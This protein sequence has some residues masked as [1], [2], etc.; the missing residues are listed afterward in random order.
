[1][2]V[3]QASSHDYLQI[4]KDLV[5]MQEKWMEQINVQLVDKKYPVNAPLLPE[6]EFQGD[7]QS[8]KQCLLETMEYLENQRPAL[9]PQ[10]SIIKEKLTEENCRKWFEAAIMMNEFYFEHFAEES[11]VEKWLPVFLAE[12]TSRVYIRQAVNQLQEELSKS[13][14][15]GCCPACGEPPRLAIVGKNGGKELVCPR[16]Y[17]SWKQKKISCAYCDNDDHEQ[18]IIMKPEGQEREQI[19]AC[20]CCKNYTK[21]IDTRVMLEKLTP[22]ILDLTTIHLD[23]IAQEEGYVLGEEELTI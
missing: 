9:K 7:I 15:K 12:S 20:D 22:E 4:Q 17:Y 16:C 5:T 19:I 3:D 8:Y 11:E 2:T 10:L 6:V 1:M 13:Q 14:V 21:V 18:I 23:Y